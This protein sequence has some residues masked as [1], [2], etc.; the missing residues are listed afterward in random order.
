LE[1]YTDHEKRKL[2]EALDL[3][4]NSAQISNRQFQH[5]RSDG[6]VA[7]RTVATICMM[8]PNQS[9]V[10]LRSGHSVR[11]LTRDVSSRGVSFVC[12]EEINLKEILVGLHVNEKDTK[13][14]FSDIVRVREISDTGFWEHAAVF[15]KS[16]TL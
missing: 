13:W 15:K 4:D 16:V 9:I 2:F 1:H 8:P 6:R 12:P 11:V 3:I 14:F 10:S 5:K 7:L